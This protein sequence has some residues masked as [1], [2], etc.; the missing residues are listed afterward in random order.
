MLSLGLPYLNE[1]E[2]SIATH[3]FYQADQIGQSVDIEGFVRMV[4]ADLR[5][6]TVISVGQDSLVLGPLQTDTL[7]AQWQ[8]RT[9]DVAAVDAIRARIDSA[10]AAGPSGQTVPQS[11]LT[12]DAGLESIRIRILFRSL[13]GQV[14]E[15]RV[16]INTALAEVLLDRR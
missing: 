15:G 2:Q 9:F 16:T 6:R 7:R 8:G 14:E 5:I 1:W 11:L 4:Q 10:G 3:F 13:A 12:A